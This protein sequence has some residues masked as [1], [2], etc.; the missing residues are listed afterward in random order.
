MHLLI[1]LAVVVGIAG[2][3]ASFEVSRRAIVGRRMERSIG[4]LRTGAQHSDRRALTLVDPP[5]RRL[6]KTDR[7]EAQP[8][9]YAASSTRRAS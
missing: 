8:A 9:G 5:R 3:F 6:V 4:A 2:V 7:R 1:V